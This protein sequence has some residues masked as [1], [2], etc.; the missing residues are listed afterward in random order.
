MSR[1]GFGAEMESI[2]KKSNENNRNAAIL[3]LVATENLIDFP[4]NEDMGFDCSYT[5]DLEE[6][7]EKSGFTDP[8]QVCPVNKK[9]ARE[10]KEIYNL[11]VQIGQYI[12]ISGHRRRKA[13]VI[14]GMTEFPCLEEKREDYITL[15][16]AVLEGNKQRGKGGNAIQTAKEAAAWKKQHGLEDEKGDVRKYIATNMGIAGGGTVQRYLKLLDLIPEFQNLIMNKYLGLTHVEKLGNLQ[17]E[18]QREIY[19]LMQAY[20]KT[21]DNTSYEG[22]EK[23]LNLSREK[24]K[25][26][27]EEYLQKKKTAESIKNFDE[28][29]KNKNAVSD[30]KNG[31]GEEKEQKKD[32][33]H[34]SE[35]AKNSSQNDNNK[36]ESF[37]ANTE[38][39]KR[40]DQ[41]VKEQQAQIEDLERR[42]KDQYE[43]SQQL[44]AENVEQRVSYETAEKVPIEKLLEV[45]RELEK[46]EKKV[47][48]NE[49]RLKKKNEHL[50]ELRKEIIR[51]EEEKKQHFN[52][53]EEV[54]NLKN[55]VKELNLLIDDLK[56]DKRDLQEELDRLNQ[57]RAKGDL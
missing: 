4:E 8:L 1:L 19:N 11:N 28:C 37:S 51:L 34:G 16:R 31:M 35:N 49:F 3:K 6:S 23:F 47:E 53:V 45:E 21:N 2:I 40:L 12:I 24:A 44:L 36:V 27:I 18:E 22:D 43:Y 38:L 20:V 14:T 13:G 39:E 25:N 29:M 57:T 54:M 10:M 50:S 7:I 32:I 33:G 55:H 5:L 26:I 46:A 41:K 56:S 52:A 48:A 30:K 9:L 42:L 15:R 17:E